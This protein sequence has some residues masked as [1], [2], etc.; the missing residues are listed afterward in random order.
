MW[1]YVGMSY[2]LAY[3]FHPE[4][5]SRRLTLAFVLAI[6]FASGACAFDSASSASSF[7]LLLGM[8][9]GGCLALVDLSCLVSKVLE[10]I[11]WD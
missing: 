10:V 3:F 2:L 4:V 9:Y 5:Q 7:L 6:S 11:F 1:V 8:E